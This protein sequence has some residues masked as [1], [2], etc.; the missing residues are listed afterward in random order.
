MI[1]AFIVEDEIP[2]FE[3][4]K[5]LVKNHALL[6]LAGT[7]KKGK[8]ALEEIERLKPQLIFLDIHLPDISG[9]DVLKVL[10]YHPLVIFTTAYDQYVV[11]AFEHDAVDFLLKPFSLQLL[12]TRWKRRC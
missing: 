5:N 7:A 3:R 4:L 1:D 8:D 10:T 9:L 6:Q 2:A 11:Q 12:N